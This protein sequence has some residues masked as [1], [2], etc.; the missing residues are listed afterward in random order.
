MIINQATLQAI[1]RNLRALF[2][3][4]LEGNAQA[5]LLLQWAMSV[6]STDT[7]EEYTWLGDTAEMEE[8]IGERAMSDLPREGM[9]IRNKKFSNGLKLPAEDIED[10]KLGQ[11]PPR[12]N[13][14]VEAFPRH[15]MRLI[16]QLL[17]HG[18]DSDAICYDK[19]PFFSTLHEFGSN[20]L[21]GVLNATNYASA[22]ILLYKMKNNRGVELELTPTHLV[23]P[24]EL[25]AT[26]KEIVEQPTVIDVGGG[27]VA[28]KWY[29]SAKVMV[30]T[31]LDTTTEWYVTCL[32]RAL[33]PF[34]IQ[35]KRPLRFRA[36]DNENDPNVFTFDEYLYGTDYRGNAGYGLPQLIIGSTGAG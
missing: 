34:I 4:A 13:G 1:G 24:P 16:T 11:L 28:N 12:I 35:V 29:N 21:T 17:T 36:L 8:W 26:A 14:M 2:F 30:K 7:I 31:G 33:K 6:I 19:K 5:Q 32:D 10:D 15:Q 3:K 25:E 22:R 23:V 27:V 9:Q 20:K 18:F